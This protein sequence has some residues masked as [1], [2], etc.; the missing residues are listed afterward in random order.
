MSRKQDITAIAYDKRGKILSVGKNSYVKTHPMQ[1]RFARWSGNSGRVFLHAEIAALIKARS[2]RVHK[3]VIFRYDR[4]GKPA[5]AKPCE[6]CQ[7]A[8]EHFGV[9]LVEYTVNS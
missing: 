5:L 2:S 7:A 1:A 9:K 3:L 4:H 6:C 8:I